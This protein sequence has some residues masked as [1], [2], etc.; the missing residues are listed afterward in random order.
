MAWSFLFPVNVGNV[1]PQRYTSE[2]CT[3]ARMLRQSKDSKRLGLLNEEGCAEVTCRS[4][5]SN[6]IPTA[7]AFNIAQNYLI[8]FT[9]TLMLNLIN[10]QQKYSKIM[11]LKHA[12]TKSEAPNRL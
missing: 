2:H 5:I 1:I 12:R 7:R 4:L 6:I 3:R 11:D 9:L 10:V 8:M